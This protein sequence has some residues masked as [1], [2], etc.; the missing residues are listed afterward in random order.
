MLLRPEIATSD[1]F[2]GSL[3]EI[4][5]LAAVE[6]HRSNQSLLG[7]KGRK[8]GYSAQDSEKTPPNAYFKAF[9]KRAGAACQGGR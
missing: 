1:L 4:V 7:D 8:T 6:A 5:A 2:V 9:P 3:N